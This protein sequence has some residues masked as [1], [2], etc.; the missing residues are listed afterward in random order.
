MGLATTELEYELSNVAA[1]DFYRS[2]W[3]Q[4]AK[5]YL[6]LDAYLRCWMDPERIFGG[7]HVLEIGA[8]ECTYT[9]LIADRYSPA[10]V[11]GVEL[12]RE[13]LLPAFR[14][15]RNPVLAVTAADCYYLPFFG[16]SFDVVLGSLVLSE[17]SAAA[18][19]V[20]EVARV[21]K[22]GGL[23]VGW[24]PNPFHMVNLYRYACKPHPV[25]AYLFW[26]WKARRIFVSGGFV[27]A[28]R[29]FFARLPRTRSR[30]LGTCVG[31]MARKVIA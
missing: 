25:N 30:F 16:A 29:Y 2:R 23:Y 8:G 6:H 17:L 11:V 20:K 26:P 7:R 24:E 31:L 22:P 4:E 12:F 21:L 5:P 9:R 1:G 3:P 10:S 27:V 28:T 15:N 19:A 18:A 14:E 13:R